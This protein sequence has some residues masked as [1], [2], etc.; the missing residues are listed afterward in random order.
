[1][2]SMKKYLQ[3]ISVLGIFFAGVFMKNFIKR[4][5]RDST[6]TIQSPS[7][8]PIDTPTFA[9]TATQ[10]PRNSPINS[11][12]SNAPTPLPPTPS[13]QTGFKNGSYTG[14]LEDAFYG[15][16]QVKAVISNG[17]LS[18][19]EFLQYPNDN[20]TSLRINEQVLPILKSE[21]IDSQGKQID[22]VSGASDTSPAFIRSLTNALNQAKK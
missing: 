11:S 9:P 14:S 1:M 17:R 20:H 21:A 18:D 19:I 3:F 15:Y 6:V 4:D 8:T 7:P 5:D 22:L 13:P 2:G 16:I 10:L 12:T